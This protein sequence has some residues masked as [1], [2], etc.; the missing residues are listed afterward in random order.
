MLAFGGAPAGYPP[1]PVHHVSL[2]A[3]HALS[4]SMYEHD[5]IVMLPL[6]PLALEEMSPRRRRN[7]VFVRPISSAD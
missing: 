2:I 5:D 7:S 6:S 3:A 4:M 1:P